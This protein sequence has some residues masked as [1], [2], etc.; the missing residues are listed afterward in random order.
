MKILKRVLTSILVVIVLA[1]AGSMIYLN[2][3]KTRA[4]PDYNESVDL[5]GLSAPVTVFRDSL[6][7]PH[8]YA[9]NEEDLYR[10]VGY[11]MAQDRMWQMDLLR[12]ITTGRLSQVLAPGLVEAD[13]L[14][15]ALD[16]SKEAVEDN[17][18]YKAVFE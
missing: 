15:R 13:R 2:N 5:E 6:G 10:T 17:V 16:F 18:L 1:S 14:F 4:L 12:R 7:I 11:V 9:A 8:I 3:V